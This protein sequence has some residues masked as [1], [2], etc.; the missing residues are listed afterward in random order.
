MQIPPVKKSTFWTVVVSVFLGGFLLGLI[1]AAYGF[2]KNREALFA[3]FQPQSLQKALSRQQFPPDLVKRVTSLTPGQ[4]IIGKVTSA[5][6][7]EF[8]LEVRLVNPFNTQS[9]TTTSVKVPVGKNDK[10]VRFEPTPGNPTLLREAS[11]TISD[12]KSGSVVNLK[13]LND[14]SKVIFLMTQ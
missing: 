11:G 13:I 6:A 3:R 1:A 2:Y 9:A 10:I 12:L 8:T 5:S 14:G 4:I 7:S